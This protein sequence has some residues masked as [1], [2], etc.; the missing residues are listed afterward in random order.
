MATFKYATQY[1]RLQLAGGAF[2]P[3]A[4]SVYHWGLCLLPLLSSSAGHRCFWQPPVCSLRLRARGFHL[5]V[6]FFKKPT[7]RQEPIVPL[8]ACWVFSAAQGLPPAAAGE[9]PPLASLLW[10]LLLRSSGSRG[11]A[12]E[13]WRVGFV[14]LWWV[15]LPISGIE[16]VSPALTGGFLSTGPPEKS[17]L[18][19]LFFF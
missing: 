9:G 6:L 3:A 2:C 10:L 5:F 17:E 1:C 14:D 13:L 4:H 19:F 8:L 12:Q 18:E 16:P 15:D 11:Q 7:V